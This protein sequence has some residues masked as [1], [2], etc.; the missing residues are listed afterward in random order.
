MEQDFLRGILV[1]IVAT[2]A[3]L[4]VFMFLTVTILTL[5]NKG[6]SP[7]AKQDSVQAP[8]PQDAPGAKFDDLKGRPSKGPEK[9]L[10]TIVE[11]S[12][13]MCPFCNRANPTLKQI[14]DNYPDKVRIVFRHFPLPMHQGAEKIHEASE[15][16]HEQGKFWPYHDELFANLG[17][18]KDDLALSGLAE[19]LGLNKGKFEQCLQSGKYK[20]LVQK[21]IKKGQESGV[22]GTPS[23]YVNQHLVVGAQP[24]ENFSKIIEGIIDPSKA[25]PVAQ[26]QA[27]PPPPAKVDFQDLEG[28]PSAGPND[29]KVTL[30]EF[31]DFFCPFCQRVSPTI[32]Q[33]MENYKGKIRRVFRHYPLAFHQGADKVHEASE[34]AHEQGKFWEFYHKVFSEPSAVRDQAGILNA[35]KSI[36][37]NEKQFEECLTS[38]K[39]KETVQKEIA[40]GSEAG[41]RGTPAVFV[42]G[43]LVSGAQPY[44]NFD[45]LVKEE[46][47]K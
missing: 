20:E 24:Y 39:Y 35:G 45:H 6:A 30:V 4:L 12:D 3:T 46:M 29:A 2:V 36:G 1:G 43:T 42:N 40:R 8:K 10:I 33:L 16:A 34:C 44:D 41:V 17:A 11:F 14:T 9:A 37:L 32:D 18:Y 26:P 31:S 22:Q 13:F 7:A 25:V 19:R 28:R 38:G 15:C 21:D 23:F 5:K 27:P 47:G